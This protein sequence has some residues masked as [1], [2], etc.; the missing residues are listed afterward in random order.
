M[1]HTG[2]SNG[3]HQIKISSHPRYLPAFLTIQFFSWSAG[4]KLYFR[5]LKKNRLTM[6]NG[7]YTLAKPRE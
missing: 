1:G 3:L 2:S 4:K 7:P 5:G 6:T